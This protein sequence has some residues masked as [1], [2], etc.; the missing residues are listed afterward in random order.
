MSHVHHLNTS[1][2]DDAMSS[3]CNSAAWS[4]VLKL[5]DEKIKLKLK[6]QGYDAFAELSQ[7]E[8]ATL[9]ERQFQEVYAPYYNLNID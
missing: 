1:W 4:N 6:D 7:L 9:V 3:V 2:V 8:Q 5:F